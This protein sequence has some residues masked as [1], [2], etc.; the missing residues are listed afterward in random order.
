VVFLVTMV[1]KLMIHSSLYFIIMKIINI[2]KFLFFLHLIEKRKKLKLK[3]KLKKKKNESATRNSFPFNNWTSEILKF[4]F[5]FYFEKCFL[6]SKLKKN[7]PM[8]RGANIPAQSGGMMNPVRADDRPMTRGGLGGFQQQS[9]TN[10]FNRQVQD[11]S[12]FLGVL[13]SKIAEINN[14]VIRMTRQMENINADNSNYL[15]Y[16]RKSE[17]LN[18]Q[19]EDLHG[20]L[21]DYNLVLDNMNTSSSIADIRADHANLKLHNDQETKVLDTLFIEKGKKEEIIKKYEKEI[22]DEKVRRERI[23]SSLTGPIRS[24][25]EQVKQESDQLQS[26]LSVNQSQI[27]EYKIRMDKMKQRIGMASLKHDALVLLDKLHSAEMKRD[28]LLIET[29]SVM[30]PAEETQKLMKQIKENNLEITSIERQCNEL[31]EIIETVKADLED[32]STSTTSN[33]NDD[34][35]SN[36]SDSFISFQFLS[37]YYLTSFLFCFK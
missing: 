30:S 27:E 7:R 10:S 3:L 14:E 17:E 20:E 6:N 1:T 35:D 4:N 37:Y 15:S 9:N 34:D 13:R 12:Y 2:E 26:Q 19:I 21:A 5:K 29:S 31:R 16:G 24:R 36:S 28:Q 33:N 25:Y 8:T 11:K 23:L 32:K 22:G 18:Q